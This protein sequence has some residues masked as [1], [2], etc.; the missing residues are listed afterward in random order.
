MNIV[1]LDSAQ[2][3]GEAD[4]PD[5]NLNKY[6]WQ[7]FLSL[8]EGEIEE[9]CWRADIV[10]SAKTPVTSN[11]INN[12]FKLKLI[13]AAGDSTGHIDHAAAAARDIPVVN[14]AGEQGD[15]AESTRQICQQ[16]C[17]QI[18]QWLNSQDISQT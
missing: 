12:A 14:V 6:G 16:V 17:E 13:I 15:T 10:I 3:T 11:I 5:I 2:L 9:R 18:N 1:M 8:D 7:Q 4:F